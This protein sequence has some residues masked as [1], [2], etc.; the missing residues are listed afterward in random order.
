M[1]GSD[2]LKF[3]FHRAAHNDDL[4]APVRLPHRVLRAAEGT[5]PRAL[6]DRGG[7]GTGKGASPR[8]ALLPLLP[9]SRS[10]YLFFSSLSSTP[11]F[12]RE[13]IRRFVSVWSGPAALWSL[14]IALSGWWRL[15]WEE[16]W[17]ALSPWRPRPPS[18]GC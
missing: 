14:W 12:S 8:P 11:L 4:G 7:P 17:S 2:Q 16:A 5:K 1:R 15:G 3:C 6:G 9:G 13:R 10:Y 18:P